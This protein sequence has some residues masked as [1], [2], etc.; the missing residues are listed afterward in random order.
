MITIVYSSHK[1][2]EY[3]DNFNEHL[4]TTSGIK[5]L[6]ILCYENHNQYSL[7]E[8]YNKGIENQNMRLLYVVIMI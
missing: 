1:D 7:A 8:V 6:E 3:N 5:N 2:K 4:V